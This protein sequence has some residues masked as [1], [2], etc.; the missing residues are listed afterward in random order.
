MRII[1]LNLPTLD[2]AQNTNFT[3]LQSILSLSNLYFL[4][5]SFNLSILSVFPK[6]AQV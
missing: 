6:L 1:K 5:L 2:F 3:D 4:P